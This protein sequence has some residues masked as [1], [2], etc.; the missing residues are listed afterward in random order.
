VGTK[1][2]PQKTKSQRNL[3][4]SMPAVPDPSSCCIQE[5]AE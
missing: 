5:L 4:R 2:S 1:Q 3:Q